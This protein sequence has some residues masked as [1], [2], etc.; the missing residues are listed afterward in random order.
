MD[1][2]AIILLLVYD[3]GYEA[4]LS[5][6]LVALPAAAIKRIPARLALSIASYNPL[7]KPPPPQELFVATKL[8]P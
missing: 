1:A 3:A 2:T 6:L 5:L 4:V 7:E 8:I